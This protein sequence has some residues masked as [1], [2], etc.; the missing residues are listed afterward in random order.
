MRSPA[1]PMKILLSAY[2]CEPHKGSE[3]AVGW[4]WARTLV[5]QGHTVHVITRSN[6]RSSV[7]AAIERERLPL[8]PSYYDLPRW[9]RRWK[10]WPG[11]LY[12]Y[13]LLWQVGAYRHAKRLQ[14]AQGFDHVH[15]VTFASF[16]LPSFMGGLGIPFTFGPVGGG[17]ATP[18]RLRAGL[19]LKARLVELVRNLVIRIAVLDPAVNFTWSRATTIACTTPETLARI[20]AR[21][22]H[23]CVVQPTIGVEPRRN[24]EDDGDCRAV[25]HRPAASF[26]FVGRLL[27]WKGL[28]LAL[29]ALAEV[30]RQVPEARLRIIGEGSDRQW[31]LKVAQKAGVADCVDWIPWMPREEVLGEYRNNTAFIFPSLHDSGGLVVLEALADGLPV[32]CLKLGGPGTLV[33]NSCGIVIEASA[34]SEDEVVASLASAMVRLAK[35]PAFT[36]ELAFQ[37]P[38]RAAELSWQNTVRQLY[39]AVE[40]ANPSLR[41]KGATSQTGSDAGGSAGVLPRVPE[42]LEDEL[43]VKLPDGQGRRS[44]AN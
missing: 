26:L 14:A 23:R 19:P 4:N 7:Q 11:G 3:P 22:R 24:A 30:R 27:Y 43:A 13:Y 25:H 37:A 41:A 36:A 17:E 35:E 40:R 18:P 29:R 2:A 34:R 15:H 31:L 32:V 33:D 42:R 21:F 8:A 38:A 10:P 20:P 28:H 1:P 39:S 16:R 44:D 9:C 5:R 12:F 6:N